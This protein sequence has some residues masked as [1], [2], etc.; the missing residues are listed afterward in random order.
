LEEK[1]VHFALLIPQLV[2]QLPYLPITFPRPWPMTSFTEKHER[3]PTVHVVSA[4][5]YVRSQAWAWG[6]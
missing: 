6:S 3:D 1:N 2:G 5:S 4:L